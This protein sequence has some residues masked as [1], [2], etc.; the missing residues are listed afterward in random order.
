MSKFEKHLKDMNDK[1]K[2]KNHPK[3]IWD[4]QNLE[5]P[6]TL[7]NKK[8]KRHW[9]KNPKTI[10]HKNFTCWMNKVIEQAIEQEQVCWK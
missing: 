3:N 9:T 2:I 6:K 7:H 8:I 1:K 10:T 4:F 5:I